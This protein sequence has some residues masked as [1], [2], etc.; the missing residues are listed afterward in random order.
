MQLHFV[1]QLTILCK[2]SG[3]TLPTGY[4]YRLPSEVEWEYAC[5]AGTTTDYYFGD[6]PS[7]LHMHA[8]YRGNSG[9]RIHP[10][11]LKK[12]NPWNLYDMYG[13]VREWVSTSFVRML[14]LMTANRMNFELVVVEVT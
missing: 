1:K 2:N 7:E 10:V 9:K 4:E 3:T 12:P 13:N 6:D 11:G 5:R 14:C 8:W